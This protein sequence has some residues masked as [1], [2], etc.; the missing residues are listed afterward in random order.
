MSDGGAETER[1]RESYRI[2]PHSTTPTSTSWRR[3][4]RGCRRGCRCRC[5]RMWPYTSASTEWRHIDWLNCVI[6]CTM[7]QQTP[8]LPSA[9]SIIRQIYTDRFFTRVACRVQT[10]DG[11]L[12]P[13]YWGSVSSVCLYAVCVGQLSRPWAPQKRP[14]RSRWLGSESRGSKE[15]Y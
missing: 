15:T 7:S 2:W 5:R 12:L 10:I 4:S 6:A 1:E 3:F 9:L 14:N 11:R 13:I 8:T